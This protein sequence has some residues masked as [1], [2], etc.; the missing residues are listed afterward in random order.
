MR[1]SRKK[2]PQKSL[3]PEF[4]RNYQ[5]DADILLVLDDEGN[6]LGEMTK[7]QAVAMAQEREMD[8]V[9]I[10][11]KGNPPVVKIVDFTEFKY[12]KEKQA[13][14]Q[15]IGSHVSE[16]KGIRISLRISDH[17]MEVK[18]T[19]AK[20]FLDRGDKVKIDMLLRGR[21]AAKQDIGYETINRFVA[22]LAQNLEIR[23]EQPATRQ[24]PK[25]TAIVAK[26]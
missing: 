18:V 23:V 24:G 5:I 22:R 15:K 17:D 1:I 26:K 25:I 7:A 9:E 4:K 21:E 14:K 16:I 6:N 10:N 8:L 11:P 20:K 19:Q 12:Q 13:R 2:R 3:I